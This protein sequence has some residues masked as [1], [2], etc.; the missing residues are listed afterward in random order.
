MGRTFYDEGWRYN[1][2]T[3]KNLVMPS[4]KGG[5]EDKI[6]RV[7]RAGQ[8]RG[9]LL[10]LKGKMRIGGVEKRDQRTRMDDNLYRGSKEILVFVE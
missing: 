7:L 10:T 8:G 9:C 4:S 1:H 6:V 2:L 3:D 5:W